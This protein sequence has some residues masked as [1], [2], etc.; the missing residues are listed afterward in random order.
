MSIKSVA[1]PCPKCAHICPVTDMVL[2]IS[3][4]A[5]PKCS[6][7]ISGHDTPE[8]ALLSL[9]SFERDLVAVPDPTA[10]IDPL[11]HRTMLL[12]LIRTVTNMWHEKMVQSADDTGSTGTPGPR[13]RPPRGFRHRN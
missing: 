10:P 4:A 1:L 9:I 6:T 13:V 2:T 3:G 11:H 7:I 12:V 5:C 8:A